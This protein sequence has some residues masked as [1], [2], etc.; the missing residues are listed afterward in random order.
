MKGVSGINLTGMPSLMGVVFNTL[1]FKIHLMEI[2][3]RK[4]ERRKERKKAKDVW[5]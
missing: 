2:K 4:K 1:Y 3:K 5:L